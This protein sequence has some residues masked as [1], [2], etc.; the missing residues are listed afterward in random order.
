[1]KYGLGD[2]TFFWRL[3]A[4]KVPFNASTV[5]D[6]INA[7]PMSVIKLAK[8]RTGICGLVEEHAV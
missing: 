5:N 2:R 3:A 7:A 1:M 6:F 4:R 8:L